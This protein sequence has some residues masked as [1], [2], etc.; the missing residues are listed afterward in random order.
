MLCVH[1]RDDAVQARKLLHLIVHKKGLRHGRGV[2]HAGCLDDDAIQFELAG[3]DTLCQLVEH[4][5]EVLANRAADAAVHH[6]NDL[7]LTLHL[8]VLCQQRV[9]DADIPKL[10]LD[11]CK[12]LAVRRR[13]DVVEQGRFARPQEASQH[14]D[15]DTLVLRL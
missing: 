6:L 10:I 8:C 3:S 9:V 15:R 12:P 14:S 2:C 1:K 5:D 11:H 4:L 7:L 13:E